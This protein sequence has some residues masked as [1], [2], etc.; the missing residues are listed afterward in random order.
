MRIP[1]S[2]NWHVI[3]LHPMHEAMVR[4]VAMEERQH[5]N[6]SL[7]LDVELACSSSPKL[8]QWSHWTHPYEADV[9]IV[10]RDALFGAIQ[11]FGP[12]TESDHLVHQSETCLRLVWH[13]NAVGHRDLR[14]CT[15]WMACGVIHRPSSLLSW[16]HAATYRGPLRPRSPH[17]LLRDL[18]LPTL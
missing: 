12:Y 13:W 1:Q 2:Q 10:E 9:M 16:V 4:R 7:D 6:R 15:Q 3:G 17:S 18:Q 5:A 11:S 14:W 8:D